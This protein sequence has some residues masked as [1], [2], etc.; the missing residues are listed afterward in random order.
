M[1]NL[2]KEVYNFRFP[3]RKKALG[4]LK[5]DRIGDFLLFRN[6]LEALR[7]DSTY[8][9]YEIVLI[10]NSLWGELAQKLDSEW[11]DK[12]LWIDL[13]KFEQSRKYRL[14]SIL[15]IKWLR[16]EVIIN[17][18]R[19]RDFYIMDFLVKT[20][21]ADEKIGH[22]GDFSNINEIKKKESDKYYSQL[23]ATQGEGQFEFYTNREFFRVL[24]PHTKLPK[25][26]LLPLEPR[27]IKEPYVILFPGGSASHKCWPAS[28]FLSVARS[29]LTHTSLNLIIAGGGDDLIVA[30]LI[31]NPLLDTGRVKNLAGLTDLYQLSQLIGHA[32]LLLTNDTAAVH[33]GAATGVQTIVLWKGDHYGRFL[34]YPEKMELPVHTVVPSMLQR[35]DVVKFA[36]VSAQTVSKLQIEDIDPSDVEAKIFELLE[37]GFEFKGERS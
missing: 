6:F 24:L 35:S 28:N 16:L 13:S 25:A 20:S 1:W 21:G 2:V 29:I 30:N 32:K 3:Y 27:K 33:M 36:Y 5:L 26:P 15:K 22:A 18:T 9:D 11:V 23:I 8:K 31:S 19:S 37:K 34:P 17:P 14:L 7:S 12:F 10:G 4:I